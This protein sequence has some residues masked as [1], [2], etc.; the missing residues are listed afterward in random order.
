MDLA[1]LDAVA[2]AKDGEEKGGLPQPPEMK[3]G[4]KHGN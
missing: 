4:P 2:P 3:A 1:Y